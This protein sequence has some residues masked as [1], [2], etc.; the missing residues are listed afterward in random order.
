MSTEDTEQ[1][2]VSFIRVSSLDED[3]VHLLI[4]VDLRRCVISLQ[5]SATL[6]SATADGKG[7][8]G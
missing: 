5:E 3:F 6:P 4:L 2:M 7:M 1:E 8:D